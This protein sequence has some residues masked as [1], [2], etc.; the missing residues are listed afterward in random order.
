MKQWLY[1]VALFCGLNHAAIAQDSYLSADQ[2][3]YST[4]THYPAIEAAL[5]TRQARQGDLQEKRGAF[6]ASI[7]QEISKRF[8]GYYDGQYADTRV[9]KP[10][11][12]Y[13]SKVYG[14]YRIS[15][16]IFPIYEDK[17]VT[18]EGGELLLGAELSLLRDSLIDERRVSV[19]NA[20]I[21]VEI[22]DIDVLLTRMQ[23][24]YTALQAYWS[25]VAAGM[26]VEV[27]DSI[28]ALTKKR[29]EGLEIRLSRGDVAEIFLT[30]NLQNIA[31]R[32]SQVIKARRELKEAAIALS[33]FSR[34]DSGEPSVPDTQELPKYF[35]DAD[36]VYDK[37]EIM[38]VISAHPQLRK[39]HQK[40]LKQQQELALG[41]NALLPQLDLAVEFSDDYGSGS[42]T[43]AEEETI[44][45][46][47]ISIPLEQN[48]AKG[49]IQRAKSQMRRLNR[50]ITLQTDELRA[51]LQEALVVLDAAAENTVIT[52][53]QITFAQR[54]EEAE[55]S[56]FAQGDSDFFLINIRE[57][58]LAD[59]KTN[60][61]IAHLEYQL[62][63]AAVAVLT[64]DQAYL[65]LADS[66]N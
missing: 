48:A 52:K 11:P 61:I 51:Q 66:G 35:P 63:R 33:L 13:N 25:W 32:E 22:A 62:A 50:E 65:Q 23:V 37:D 20:L 43:R 40:F 3:L 15:D 24:Q 44:A 56:R 21:D 54:M 49:K 30:E 60:H 28:L 6:D 64:M 18:N 58:A 29:Q 12:Y 47:R 5:A 42:F 45:S 46:L 17:S 38:A 27:I 31:R 34:N 8:T 26:R 9:V 57:E 4:R 53:Q 59:A 2:V 39:L 14:G 55:R 16:G 19:A 36:A 10:L 1:G 7:E 41:E